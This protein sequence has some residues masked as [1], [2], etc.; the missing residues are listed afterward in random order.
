MSDI[1]LNVKSRKTGKQISKQYRRENLVPGVYYMNGQP[2]IPV[3]SDPLS[4]RHIVYTKVTKV[5]NLNIEG[6]SETKKCILKNVSFHPVTDKLLHFDLLGVAEGQ[7][8]Q[9][10]VP[11]ILIGGIPIGV[12]E[13]G[14][15][16]QSLHKIPVKCT[17]QYLPSHIELNIAGL[18]MGKSIHVR[19]LNYEGVVFD[20]PGET[21]IVQIAQPRV[22]KP[23]EDGEP[24]AA[25][26]PVA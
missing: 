14:N 3:L 15:M 24:A 2:G 16:Q 21:V 7:T 1:V 5:I 13:G 25:A 26:E 9:A 8:M 20:L 4:L 6:D 17:P 12:R 22:N 18:K 19:D 10:N 23:G 11:V